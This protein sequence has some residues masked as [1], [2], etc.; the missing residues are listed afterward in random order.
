MRTNLNAG[1]LLA[2]LPAVMVTCGKTEQANVMTAA[3]TGIVNTRPPMTYI[4]VR[5]TRYS[6]T[7]IKESG[8]FVINLTTSKMVRETDFCGVKSGRDVQKIKKCGLHLAAAEKVSAP[9]IEESPL[10]L[11]CRVT[12]IK[13][14][15]SHDM[16]LA[17]IVSVSVDSRYID[18]KGKIN[19]NQAGLMAYSHGEYFA[20]GRKLGGF[21]FSVRKKGKQ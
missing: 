4:S 10:A 11:E 13:P 3:W 14:F 9:I 19:L 1:T 16:F 17:E 5:P 8:E 6:Y 18:S 21:G 2:P 20:L 15:G 7:I 12:E